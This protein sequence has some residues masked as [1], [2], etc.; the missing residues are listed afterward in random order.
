M[1]A[2]I[3]GGSSG[4]QLLTND[5]NDPGIMG[6]WHVTVNFKMCTYLFTANMCQLAMTLS[7]P[8][9]AFSVVDRIVVT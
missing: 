5:S 7:T 6:S 9:V 2:D 8:F 4:V 1:Y 3:R